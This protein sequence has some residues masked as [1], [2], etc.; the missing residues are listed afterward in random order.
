MSDPYSQYYSPPA[1][2]GYAPPPPP[3]G[4]YYQDPSYQPQ[5]PAY[6]GYQQPPQQDPAYPYQ[7]PH[8]AY[9]PPVPYQ[10][11]P[12]ENFGPPRRQD[13][14]GP[15]M[16]GGFQHGQADHQFGAY[17]NSNPQGH[18]GYYGPPDNTRGYSPSPNPQQQ[19]QQ[20]P[21]DPSNPHAQYGEGA[22]GADPNAADGERG[23]G[24]SLIGGA[25]GYYLG[26]K[27]NHGFL[28]AVGG[29][30]LGNIIGDKIKEH[31]HHEGSGHPGS[32]HGSSF[33]GSSW[34]GK[35]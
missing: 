8:N 26:H 21:Y 9:Q 24:S 14:F 34:G 33:G 18:Y 6:G 27:K 30:I 16:A 35:W 23:L 20:P 10:G 19:Q 7:Q 5:P 28:G 17:D 15:P 31:R 12:P 3:G 13:S 32:S 25:A 1:P 11:A 29:A 22:P 2:G 4:Q